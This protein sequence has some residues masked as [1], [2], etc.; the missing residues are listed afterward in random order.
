MILH[1][2]GI[3]ATGS[4]EKYL[5]LPS[6]ISQSKVKFFVNLVDKTWQQIVNWKFQ[7]L[8]IAGKAIML[9]SVLQALPTYTMV[10]FLLLKVIVRR[11]NV[12][13]KEFWSG[14]HGDQSKIHWLKWSCLGLPK[15]L[16]GLRFKD[17][18]SF[19]LALLSKQA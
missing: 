11:L 17:M 1:I 10:I 16:G 6:I 7:Y 19:N 14:F 2:A 4:F 3:R 5:G 8:S 9:K 15:N 12:P 13:L 18:A